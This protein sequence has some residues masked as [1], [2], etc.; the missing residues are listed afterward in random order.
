[1]SGGIDP[2]ACAALFA[3]IQSRVGMSFDRE[4]ELRELIGLQR[5]GNDIERRAR[6]L[7]QLG[8]IADSS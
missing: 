6:A 4:L 8:R 1:M 3:S 7:G 2:K 5:A